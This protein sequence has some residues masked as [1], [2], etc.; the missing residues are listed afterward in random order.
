MCVS[1]CQCA[2]VRFLLTEHGKGREVAE[3]DGD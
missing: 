1:P 2:C 3:L